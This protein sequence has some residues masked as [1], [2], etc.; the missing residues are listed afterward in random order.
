MEWTSSQKNAID[1]PVSDIIVSAAAGSGKTAVM[2][3]RI[4]NRLTGDNPTSIDRILV[5][6]YTNA[7]ASEIRDRVMKKILEKLSKDN[8]ENLQ[9]QLVLLN[10]A[11]FCTIHS[12]CL[13][14][15]KKYF[16]LLGIDPSVKTGDE[17]DISIILKEAV[18]NVVN[19]YLANGD[20][21]FIKLIDAYAGGKEFIIENI[22]LELYDFSRTMPYSSSWLDKLPESYLGD[23]DAASGFIVSCVRLAILYAI[24]EYEMAIKLIEES[25]TCDVWLSTIVNEKNQ[26]ENIVNS[27]VS[28]DDY[29]N[30]IKNMAYNTLTPAKNQDEVMK[31]RIKDCR[32]NAKS[33]A[34]DDM[35]KYYLILSPENIK[36][37]NLNIY[38]HILKLVEAVKLVGDEFSRLKREKNLV[39]FSD[40]EHMTLS[41]L[42]D[43]DGNPSDI[44]YAVSA[45]F[46]EI[47]VDEFQDCNNIQNEIFSLISGRIRNKPNL[48]CVGDMKQ[49]IYKFR[50]ANPLNFRR[51]CDAYTL[52]DGKT[53]NPSNKILLSTN[54][55]SRPSILKFVNSVFSQLMSRECGEL[56]YNEEEMLNPSSDF[57]FENPDADAIDID[58]INISNDFGDGLGGEDK[59]I[60]KTEAEAIHIAQKIKKMVDEGY[61]LYNPK[62]KKYKE[63]SYSDFVILLRGAKSSVG[64]YSKVFSRLAVPLY[65]D[66]NGYFEAE[67]IKFLI[68]LLK[69]IDNPDDDI[70][71]VSVMKNVI[72][73][74]DENELLEIRLGTSK[75]LSFYKCIMRYIKSSENALKQ[76]LER[77]ISMLEDYHQK[78]KYMETDVFLSYVLS[79]IDYFV[80]LS[81]FEDS[82]MRIE[83]VRFLVQKAKNFENN[84]FKGIFSFIRYV[85][86]IKNSKSDDC[87]KTI[88]KDNDVV[89]LMSIHKSKGL[90]FPVVI[91]AGT[92]KGYNLEDIK[93]TMVFHK[94]LGIGA[95]SVYAD[96]GYKLTSLNKVAIKHKIRYE[97]ASEELRVLYVAL[98]RAVD[99]L[100]ITGAVKNG[101]SF[102]N[103]VEKKASIQ[104]YNINPYTVFKSS[105]FLETILLASARSE[106]CN[107]GGVN[108]GTI[109]A[110]GIDFNISTININSLS[111]PENTKKAYDWQKEYDCVTESYD[112][113][114]SVLDYKYPYAESSLVSGNISVTE[115]KKMNTESQ[116]EDMFYDSIN[117]KKPSYFSNSGRIYGAALGTLVHLCMEKLD[118]SH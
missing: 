79:D 107:L 71:I 85:E 23:S 17:A 8:S 53:V 103:K 70:A 34:R 67:E 30:S 10:N 50:D 5:V 94:D 3:E 55:R 58:I 96:K 86:N 14:L 31:K 75:N 21:A 102:L 106:K 47:Y 83:N 98:T 84:N 4:I 78:S 48:F 1:I 52:Y 111:L 37:D 44:A 66:S 19:E 49:S 116:G 88:G 20:E 110:D 87:A 69:I 80:Y 26:L 62:E 24:K 51:M 113:I 93:G 109:Y 46:D 16:Y 12:F 65:C 76:K 13:E 104:D 81:A 112:K 100:I 2:A 40:Y 64:A 33:V 77:F 57:G 35:L 82:K 45:D 15:I 7:A 6:T 97:T 43:E 101:S 63:A 9:K 60:D 39:D 36:S 59:T 28:Y 115:I 74:F 18:S 73:S 54:F 38:P 68:N 11:H 41:L 92:G 29:Y 90:E 89:R 25:G 99:K 91:L 61:R 117:L 118:F 32:D 27:A 114:S 42:A 72:F 56:I 95:E 22:I 105:C 108:R